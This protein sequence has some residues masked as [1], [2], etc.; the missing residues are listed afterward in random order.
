MTDTVSSYIN[1]CVDLVI[2]T[3]KIVTYPNNKPWVT[4]ELKSTINKKK[5]I[6][7]TGDPLAK[8]AASREVRNEIKKRPK[9][10]IRAR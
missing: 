9:Q 8:K 2:P 3:K 4:K 6:F 7:F 1:F 5:H 10:S